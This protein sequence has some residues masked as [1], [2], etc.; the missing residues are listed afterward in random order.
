MISRRKFITAGTAA[1]AVLLLPS[2]L[3]QLGTQTAAARSGTLD[4]RTLS[5]YVTPLT[6]LPAMPSD[7]TVGGGSVDNY[8]IGARQF[9]QQILPPDQPQT[10]VWGYG[11]IADPATFH[12]PAYTIEARAGRQVRVAW[13]NQ[14]VDRHGDYLPHMLPVDPTLHWANPPGGTS[15]RD[16][17][18]TFT[19]T[20][21]PYTGPVPIVTHLH[22][23]HTY[24]D[25]DGYPEA[26]YLPQAGNIP[27][28]YARVGSSY[29]RFRVASQARTGATWPAGAAVLQYSNDQRAATL[30]IHD[31]ALGMTRANV[32]AGLSGFYLLRGGPD[33]LPADVL[34]GPAPKPGD[35]PGTAYH[36]IP[37]VIQDRS[38]NANGSLF[39]PD[40]RAF[41][42]DTDP[43]GPWI[44][45]SDV[46]P[47]WNPES[48]GNTIVVNGNT[49]PTLSVEQR[50][51]R[52]RFLNACNTRTLFLKIASDPLAARPARAALP[53]WQIGSDGGFLPA[54][55]QLSYVLLAVA[56]RADV[57]VDFTDVPV[58][59]S[60]YL[61]NEGPDE[62]YGGGE[63]GEAE[64][65]DPDTTG[66]VMRFVVGP[67]QGADNSVPPSRLSL[68]SLPKL[69]NPTNT[70]QVTLNEIESTVFEGAPAMAMLGTF[71]ADGTPN[72]LGWHNAITE[73]PALNS[74][75]VW[76][77]SNFTDDGHPIHVHLV[78]FEVINREAADGTV[79]G[80][81]SWETG[82]KDTVLALP[83]ETTRIKAKFDRAGLYV[84]HC[85]IVDHEDNE[86]MR[87][88]RIG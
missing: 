46:S 25:S 17:R 3:R 57:I 16:S 10:M 79:R 65:A 82:T 60:L 28:G 68:P 12:T 72:P 33:D 47:I 18:P 8:R 26:W 7:G 41:F 77:I 64:P 56:E 4:P 35:P 39:F 74:T 27:A 52:F 62:P 88:Y 11:S 83:G 50:R 14:L 37:I 42:G 55:T 86:M 15:G 71:N 21:G 63:P 81:R 30:W 53:I 22:G 32:Y 80:P 61:I 45:D 85:H 73:T 51:Y 78:Q 70:R 40:S 24:D 49:W 59:T 75:E 1:G 67:R 84:W 6:I 19:S 9:R 34:P 66:Q 29:D 13:V 76:E 5:K 36:E 58:G 69:G 2:G 44:P 48:F 23:A 20:P 54:P 43:D 31:H 87:P 38:F